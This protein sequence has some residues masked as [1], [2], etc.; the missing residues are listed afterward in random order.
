MVKA[1]TRKKLRVAIAGKRGIGNR[2]K[3]DSH[4]R[5]ELTDG[6]VEQ[7]RALSEQGWGVRPLARK[8]GVSPSQVCKIV[9]FKSRLG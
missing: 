8:F 5:A 4:P 6:E 3:G 2:L 7:L 1:R 9:G